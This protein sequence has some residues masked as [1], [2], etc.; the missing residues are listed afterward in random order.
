MEFIRGVKRSTLAD[1]RISNTSVRQELDIFSLNSTSSCAGNH[2][3]RV[4]QELSATYN[5]LK[6]IW[7]QEQA[8][9]SN[10]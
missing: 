2:L 1:E 3:K 8:V 9:Q 4:R 10:P 7:F 6:R 5:C